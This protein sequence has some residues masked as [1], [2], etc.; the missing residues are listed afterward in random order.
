MDLV[1]FVWFSLFHISNDECDSDS[2]EEIVDDL[3]EPPKRY[4]GSV[5]STCKILN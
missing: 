4:G 5:C 3:E 2:E 1:Y